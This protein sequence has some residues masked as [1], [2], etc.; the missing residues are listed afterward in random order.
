[1]SGPSPNPGQEAAAIAKVRQAIAMLQDA[2]GGSDPTGEL[3]KA[4]LDSIK[5]LG[6]AA[7]AMQGAPGVGQEALRNA[8]MQARQ[9]APMQALMRSMAAG[10]G[11][12][13]PAAAMG[14]GT[15]GGMP[16]MSPSPSPTE[17]A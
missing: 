5:K 10:G 6:G 1:M 17:G 7:P 9:T 15:P 11:A 4:I 14:G 13:G 2:F 3:G 12:G 16:A 8:L